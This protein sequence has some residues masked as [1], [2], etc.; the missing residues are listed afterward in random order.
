MSAKQAKK[1]RKDKKL[2]ESDSERVERWAKGTDFN[3]VKPFGPD[4]GMFHL[5]SEALKKLKD[6]TEKV[7]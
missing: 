6:L 7:L 5:P 4:I 1:D 2:N 3:L